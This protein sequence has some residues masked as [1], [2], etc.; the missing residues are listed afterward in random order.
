MQTEQV[1]AQ[2]KLD[3]TNTPDQQGTLFVCHE[4]DA[5]QQV[6][7]VVPGNDALCVRCG[8]RLFRNPKSDINKPLAYTI[9]SLILFAVANS[10]PI[11]SITILGIKQEATISD[12]ALAFIDSGSPEIA[13]LVWLPSVLIPGLTIT[14]LAYVLLSIRLQLNW[15]YAKTMLKWI[16][17]M[18]PWGMM[19]VFLLGI[20][21]SLVKLVSL[22][23][24]ALSIGFYAFLILIFLYAATIA[25]LEP[26]SLWES[27]AGDDQRQPEPANG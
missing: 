20:I 14:F 22:A 6:P 7:D 21:V 12:A 2:I 4:C 23:E 27:L 5:L 16:I 19:D 11:M 26:H 1:G 9:A 10:Q 3:D 24:V 17:R 18:L 8:T 15:P 13:A 25:S